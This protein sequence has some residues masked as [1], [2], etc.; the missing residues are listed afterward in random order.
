MD[1]DTVM[2]PKV[3]GLRKNRLS[4]GK[5]PEQPVKVDDWADE[6]FGSSEPLSAKKGKKE[7]VS[8]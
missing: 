2:K 1:V 5:K 8:T 3:D 4:R 6:I 7:A